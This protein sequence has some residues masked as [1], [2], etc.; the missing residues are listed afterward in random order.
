MST[1][2][3]VNTSSGLI[4]E[5]IVLRDVSNFCHVIHSIHCVNVIHCIVLCHIVFAYGFILVM[6][7]TLMTKPSVKRHQ[8]EHS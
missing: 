3:E 2:I 7:I 8:L 1:L 6:F 5:K 4:K